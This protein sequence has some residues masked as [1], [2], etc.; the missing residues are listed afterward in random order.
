MGN[1]PVPIEDVA[2]PNP[3]S[4]LAKLGVRIGLDLARE[5]AARAG[6]AWELKSWEEMG[7]QDTESLPLTTLLLA[8][9]A[10]RIGEFVGEKQASKAIVKPGPQTLKP[11]PTPQR[12][13]RG[14]K[15]RTV[16]HP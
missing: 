3:L 2:D 14:W 16:Q 4:L 8:K 15:E 13:R 5:V 10:E 6:R 7:T 12:K 9:P 11:R 1:L